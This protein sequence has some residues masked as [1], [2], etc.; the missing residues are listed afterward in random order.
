M[1]FLV[2]SVVF[3]DI[4][5]SCTFKVQSENNEMHVFTGPGEVTIEAI[6]D[7]YVNFNLYLNCGDF[8]STYLCKLLSEI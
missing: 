4:V 8:L 7:K 3:V 1:T 2:A 5:R 6:Y